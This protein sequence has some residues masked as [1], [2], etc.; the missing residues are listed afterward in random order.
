MTK[1]TASILEWLELLE[2]MASPGFSLPR[3]VS[4]S[5]SWGHTQGEGISLLQTSFKDPWLSSCSTVLIDSTWC[6]SPLSALTQNDS[7]N[8]SITWE[9][10]NCEYLFSAD[11]WEASVELGIPIF[12]PLPSVLRC[13]IW[14]LLPSWAHVFTPLRSYSRWENESHAS[15]FGRSLAIFA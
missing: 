10:Q 6:W 4:F 11:V 15:E 3:P 1:P 7:Q 9:L 14:P 13:P 12:E 8:G 5:L 2:G